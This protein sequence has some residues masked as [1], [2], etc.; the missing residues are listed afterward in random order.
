MGFAPLPWKEFS[1]SAK[2]TYRQQN[3][4]FR[5]NSGS[6]R[7]ACLNRSHYLGI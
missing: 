4:M 5:P 2:A 6:V 7:I 1:A 3:Y